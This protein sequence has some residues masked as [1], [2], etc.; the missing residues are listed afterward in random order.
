MNIV[1]WASEAGK[2]HE[3]GADADD[4]PIVPKYCRNC[5]HEVPNLYCS[6]CGQSA[7]NI[8]VSFHSLIM[9][10]LG[11]Y[12]TFDSKLFRS[13]TPLFFKP[14]FLTRAFM[15][16]KRVRYIPPLRL[17]IFSS[18]IFFLTIASITD[19]KSWFE[20]DSGK[21]QEEIPGIVAPVKVSS[22]IGSVDIANDLSI[23]SDDAVSEDS[24]EQRQTDALRTTDA[25]APSK[26]PDPPASAKGQERPNKKKTNINL[27]SSDFDEKTWW[28]RWLNK[29][30]KNQEAKLE[31]MDEKDLATA[32]IMLSIKNVP[33]ALFLLMPLFA[34]FLKILYVRRD[35]L[36]IDHLIFAFHFHA[37]L[38]LFYSLLIWLKIG[39]PISAAWLFTPGILLVSPAYL[40]FALKYVYRQ[41][42]IKTFI[43][44]NMLS[45]MYFFSLNIIV[46]LVS[47]IT[48]FM[49]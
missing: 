26:K 34:F 23:P 6:Y 48:L 46:V 2:H 13:V 8:R 19:P 30:I 47:I 14:G 22:P 45:F 27:M 33:K 1:N 43:K 16:G 15:Q 5:G 9:D 38:F 32:F 31:S 17:Y 12:F 49:I 18:I 44:F 3:A 28:G 41:G 11:D 40:F 42:W 37:F 20:D 29:N 39:S 24:G 25:E 35:P 36:Y 10:F 4:Q 7:K 21:K